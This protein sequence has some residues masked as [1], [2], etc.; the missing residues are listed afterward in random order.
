MAS[1]EEIL[2]R[3]TSE[4]KTPPPIPVGTYHCIVDGMPEHGK[5]TKK[6]TDYLRFKYKIVAAMEDVDQRDA[7]EARVVGKTIVDD[8]YITDNEITQVMFKEFLEETL[9]IENPDGSKSFQELV[10]EAPNCQLLVKLE[11]KVTDD[12]KR[13]YA[14]VNSTAHV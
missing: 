13:T 12:G 4:V 9:G 2:K 8:K 11:H 5:S 7:L 14:R 10:S 1:F 6:Q 3:P